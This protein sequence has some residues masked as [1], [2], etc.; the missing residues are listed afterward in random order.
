MEEPTAEIATGELDPD[1]RP[2]RDEPSNGEVASSVFDELREQYADATEERRITIPIR[3]GR[4][5]GNLA[6]RCGPGDWTDYRKRAERIFGKG[7]RDEEAEL[8]FA[9]QTFVNCADT[10]LFRP[11]DATELLPMHETLAEWR[12]GEP[13]RFDARL[14]QALKIE[15]VPRSSTAICRLVFGKGALTDAFAT[16]DAFLKEAIPGDEEEDEDG[17]D[18]PT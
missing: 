8:T 15:P 3:P 10:I 12:G 17:S 16:L 11:T 13:V 2:E 9:A 6:V 7:R 1:A 5:N 18:R 14:A 4:Y